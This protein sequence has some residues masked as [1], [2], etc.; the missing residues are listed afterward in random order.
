M[1]ISTGNCKK[2]EVRIQQQEAQDTCTHTHT[3]TETSNTSCKC[4]IFEIKEVIVN[5][6]IALFISFK[7]PEGISNQ[8]IH[9]KKEPDK[10]NYK[11]EERREV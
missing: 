7:D 2:K 10:E 4:N 8:R 6:F 11:T 3:E 9:L 1:I 5:H